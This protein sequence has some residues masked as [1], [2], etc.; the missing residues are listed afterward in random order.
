MMIVILSFH[1]LVFPDSTR[2]HRV[3]AR[4]DQIL[5]D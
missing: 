3:P 4:V 1:K 2:E 5:L